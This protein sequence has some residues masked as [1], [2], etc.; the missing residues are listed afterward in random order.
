MNYTLV[1]GKLVIKKKPTSP[2]SS[3]ST[4]S[5]KKDC[6]ALVK[7]SHYDYRGRK[8]KTK[9]THAKPIDDCPEQDSKI[10]SSN[11][12]SKDSN[13]KASGEFIRKQ[14]VTFSEDTKTGSQNENDQQN[15]KKNKQIQ[16]KGR[17]KRSFR[18]SITPQIKLRP[19]NKTVSYK[20]E[21]ST[22]SH[23]DEVSLIVDKK[24]H[25]DDD[26]LARQKM[27]ELMKKSKHGSA[28]NIPFDSMF[29]QKKKA[30]KEESNGMAINK[31]SS[32]RKLLKYSS[33]QKQGIW[34]KKMVTTYSSVASIASNDPYDFEAEECLISSKKSVIMANLTNSFK[35]NFQNLQC[36]SAFNDSSPDFNVD[37][38][39]DKE[40]EPTKQS[41][42]S[43]ESK[44]KEKSIP[45]KK[46]DS[47][48]SHR[49]NIKRE[50]SS[51][52]TIGKQYSTERSPGLFS[53]QIDKNDYKQV[54]HLYLYTLY[55][56]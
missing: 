36:F 8:N 27:R 35:D 7:N 33:D 25:L 55:I 18:K 45:L 49:K 53:S 24:E 51:K 26:N 29:P 2:L 30:H 32:S 54:S 13:I 31:T 22:S 11:S 47:E 48:K 4:S 34:S 6:D 41:S 12:P 5:R 15:L 39:G 44:M 17:V 3:T 28:V 42:R 37:E 16:K 10:T 14:Q 9:P 1:C 19:R 50:K 40:F 21:E 38:K 23:M 52:Q 43:K 46:S 20:E 56:S